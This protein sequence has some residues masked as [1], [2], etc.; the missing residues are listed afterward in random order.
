VISVLLPL[1]TGRGLNDR[2]HWMQRARQT[3]KQ[4]SAAWLLV[5]KH[6]LPC[7]VTITRL[8]AGKLDDD[9]LQ[10]AMKAIRDGIADRLGIDD[11][12]K[13]VRWQYAQEKCKRGESAVRVEIRAE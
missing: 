8:S 10:G 1:T 6:P 11:A 4:R 5:P 12:D 7:V 2:M 9:N 3:K 13:R